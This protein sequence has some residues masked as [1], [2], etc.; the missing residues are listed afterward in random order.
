M[1]FFSFISIQSYILV[2]VMYL[3]LITSYHVFLLKLFHA[4]LHVKD[5]EKRFIYFKPEPPYEFFL[6]IVF[7]ISPK[8]W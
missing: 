4:N 1:A 5:L 6:S 2:S 3:F 8:K 7:S